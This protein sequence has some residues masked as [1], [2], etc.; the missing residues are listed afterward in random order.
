[1]SHEV[2]TM[3]YTGS[4]PWHHLGKEVAGLQT[5]TEAIIAAGLN[6]DVEM[7]PITVGKDSEPSKNTKLQ[8]CISNM[9]LIEA[10]GMV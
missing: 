7:V 6:W 10:R 3:M 8:V 5:S 1:M 9:P 4:E 2:E